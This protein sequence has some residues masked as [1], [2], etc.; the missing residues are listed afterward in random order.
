MSQGKVGFAIAGSGMGAVT[1]AI[2]IPHI[3]D[4]ELIAVMSRDEGRAKSFAD[5]HGARRYYT[6]Y[7]KMLEDDEVDVVVIVT[8]NSMH[9]DNAIAAA[10]AG[11]HVVVEKPLA[12]TVEQGQEIIDVCHEQG[13]MLTVIYQMRFC[14]AAQKIKHAIDNNEF[15]PMILCDVIDKEYREP[16]YY[17][18][19]RWN[20][21][22][23]LAGG[24]CLTLQSTHLV[25]LMH[26]F[27]GPV[28]KVF[29]KTRTAVH[30][31]DVEDLSLTMFTFRNG[32]LG[33]LT[34]ST[35]VYPAHKHMVEVNGV[36][37]S[38]IMN[39]EYDDMLFWEVKGSDEKNDFPAGFELNDIMDPHFFPTYRHRLQ[40]IDIVDAIQTGRPSAITGE[41]GLKSVII[42]EAI[43]RSAEL[44]VEVDVNM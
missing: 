17:G 3:P 23:A 26:W 40:L 18:K 13:V 8:P 6:D 39:G 19:D 22:K 12:T 21:N 42:K 2:E 24:G 32:G 1:H 34:S 29:A 33:T 41:E 7:D 28:D 5:T 10:K 37:G 27:M 36:N 35:C 25:D 14:S 43:Y 16:A 4:A 31:I 44:G 30:D 11:K 20:G 38:A 15:G 9:H